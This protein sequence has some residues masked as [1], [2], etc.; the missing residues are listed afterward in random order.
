M[1]VVVK[2]YLW[3]DVLDLDALER[4]EP[5]DVDLVVKVADVADDRV[6]AHLRHVLGGD[7]ALVA[8]GGD[9]D[10]RPVEG[11]LDGVD[12]VASHARL[13]RADRVDLGDDDAAALPSEGLAAALADVAVA[14]DARDLAADHDVG[15]PVDAVDERV[16]A[17]V[18]VVE[19]ALGDRVVDV[20]G[21]EG[22]LAG[23]L[24]LVQP[25]DA[26][27]GLLG[28]APDLALDLVEE[29]GV[30]LEDVL[31][32][33]VELVHLLDAAVVLEE[34]GVVLGLEALHDH[35][36]GVAA[37]VDDQLRA[38]ALAKVEGLEGALP[39]VAER[40][41]LPRE[42]VGA[43]LGDRGGGVVLGGEDVARAPPHLGAEAL[44]GLDQHGGLDGHVERAGDAGAS[45]GLVVVLLS[46]RHESGHFELSQRD[47]L[48]TPVGEVDVLDLV[49]FH[50]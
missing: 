44:E 23:L 6:V 12:L 40:L 17:A 26:G 32:D 8:G 41:A 36:G 14:A 48:A 3:L 34:R 27:G 33:R 5:G 49:A 7:D 20:D 22:Q 42:H 45:E 37:V 38:D 25:H 11:A 19:L 30:L 46:G 4:L 28:D 29:A 43:V 10:L 9:E 35:Q 24:E 47:F 39:V 18:D 15:R 16:A 21:G 2:I 1:T 50:E 31:D 13:E